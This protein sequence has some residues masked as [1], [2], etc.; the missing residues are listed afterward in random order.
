MARPKSEDRRAALLDSAAKVFAEHGLG[1]P[2]ALV[3]KTAGVS[4]GSFFTYFKTK[5]DLVNELYGEIRHDL[6]AA[7]ARDFPRRASVRDRLEHMFSR[8]VRWG[9]DHPDYRRTLRLLSMSNAIRPEVRSQTQHLYAE[10]DRIYEDAKAQKKL[11][12]V[13]PQMISQVLKALSEATMDLVV[14]HPDQAEA[15]TKSGFQMLWGAYDS[16]P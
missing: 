8:W 7:I 3:S 6:A 1:A 10:S 12:N 15:L 13:P 4:E 9:V 14:A 2:T 16:K 11:V 5:D